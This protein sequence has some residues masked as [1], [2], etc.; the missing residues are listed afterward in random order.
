MTALLNISL[1]VWLVMICPTG[2]AAPM[3]P[4][5]EQGIGPQTETNLKG[6]VRLD[7]SDVD[8]PQAE[9]RLEEAF[10]EEGNYLA[11][12][13]LAA[14][15]LRMEPKAHRLRAMYALALA[16]E[17]RGAEAEEQLRELPRR[18]SA[19]WQ[20]LTRA[21]LARNTGDMQEASRRVNKALA[22]DDGNPYA[23]NVAGT[24]AFARGN[25]EQAAERFAEAVRLSPDSGAYLGNLGATRLQQGKYTD[26]QQI[27]HH[28]VGVNPQNCAAR[29]NY[30]AVL[31]EQAD[32]RQAERQLQAC[33][34]VEPDSQVAATALLDVLMRRGDF[35]AAMQL[36]ERPRVRVNDPQIA[37]ARLALQR[38][39][40]QQAQAR[41]E[42][43]DA[44]EGQIELLR[45]FAEA[46][47]GN[48]GAGAD[49]LVKRQGQFAEQSTNFAAYAVA[50]MAFAIAAGKD[51]ERFGKAE[52]TGFDDSALRA[53]WH[54]LDGLA[55]ASQ[56]DAEGMR[57]ALARSEGML[58][59]FTL[60][61]LSSAQYQA[62]VGSP[63][64]RPLAGGLAFYFWQFNSAALER[65]QVAAQA[66][67]QLALPRL[68]LALAAARLGKEKELVAA[69]DEALELAPRSYTA[70]LMRGEV[71]LRQGQPQIALT[72]LR[73]ANEV[74][75]R[76][77]LALR[78]GVIA[79][80]LGESATARNY[81]EQ[82]LEL[83][84][85]SFVTNNQLAWFLASRGEDL[86]R[87]L[88][89]AKSADKL[90][91][92]NASIQ[93]TIG[94]IYY[95]QEDYQQ[96][97]HYVRAA[98]EHAGWDIPLIGW[99]L[100]RVELELGNRDV[101]RNLLKQLVSMEDRSGG[102]DS[103]AEKLLSEI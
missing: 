40:G 57:K 86:N 66:D 77:S 79:Q 71:A 74:K 60:A 49:R 70:N 42:G 103:Q 19:A 38:G 78:V 89:L 12:L 101:A 56:G 11:T 75:A 98:F 41:L 27:L 6:N 37:Y 55:R 31:V 47:Q 91:P 72:R 82:A 65:F 85:E 69:L 92:G 45:A 54:F 48:W 67:E 26:A 35:T 39:D 28:A 10:R 76:S 33:L 53:G 87:A 88:K 58:S 102:L 99:T 7:L 25:L 63:A 94:Y 61:G 83:E 100:A 1:L 17:G 52:L 30:A 50:G 84:P 36:L 97:A 13:E 29:I 34:L 46:M 62:L 3:M 20:S 68:F 64:L 81:Y 51:S 44:D 96:S 2:F 59:G 80:A 8:V 18:R 24:I 5:W 93:H 73:A 90:H 21:V 15:L 32:L 16:V 9:R 4:D 95:L 14:E 22:R 43:R 23:W